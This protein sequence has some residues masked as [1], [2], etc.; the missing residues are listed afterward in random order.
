MSHAKKI[1]SFMLSSVAVLIV[2]AQIDNCTGSFD[3]GLLKNGW[4]QVYCKSKLMMSSFN[5]NMSVFNVSITLSVDMNA[6][7]RFIPLSFARSP[8]VVLGAGAGVALFSLQKLSP[9][10]V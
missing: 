8:R 9:E 7:G 1:K 5:P 2:R 3:L 4:V 10:C 6:I